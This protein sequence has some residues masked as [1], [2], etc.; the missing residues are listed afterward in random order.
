M[1][2]VK[3]RVIQPTEYKTLSLQLIG[4]G[5]T[6]SWL[7]PHVVRM[8]WILKEKRGIDV[9]VRFYDPDTVSEENCFRQNF[10][11]AE[12]GRYKAETLAMRYGLAWG[13]DI[14]ACTKEYPKSKISSYAR[15]SH[16][17]SSNMAVLIGCV[18][19]S[20]ARQTIL[21]NIRDHDDHRRQMW[22]L[23]CGNSNHS[24]QVLL[25]RAWKNRE[26]TPFA[27]NGI[28]SWTPLPN[29]VHPELTS[30][31]KLKKKVKREVDT[32]VNLALSG[33]Q[34]L[35]I[36]QAIAMI[37]GNYLLE[38]LVSGSLDKFATYIN[39]KAGSMSSVLASDKSLAPYMPEVKVNVVDE[40]YYVDGVDPYQYAYEGLP[41][42]DED[43]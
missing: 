36:N 3:S 25:G 40:D 14:L 38:F 8:A 27:I 6:G 13:I 4:C 26:L 18:D 10:C 20:E 15:Y 17:E 29:E 9:Y 11:P 34:G 19:T 41:E 33:D 43:E 2:L 1:E 39:L 42:N 30:D 24:G 37:A 16:I 22:W 32:C 31:K 7:A 28:T 35:M 12:I 5:G 21:R 23:D